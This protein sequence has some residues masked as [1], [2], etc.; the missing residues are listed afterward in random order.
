[1]SRL[2]NDEVKEIKNIYSLWDIDNRGH[3][4]TSEL[5]REI[6]LIGLDIHPYINKAIMIMD[7]NGKI[8]IKD[9]IKFLSIDPSSK[10][11]DEDYTH[12]FNLIDIN[13][14]SSIGFE[15]LAR[16]AD[17]SSDNIPKETLHSMYLST[18]DTLNDT[19]DF[20]M[21]KHILSH[22]MPNSNSPHK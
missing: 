11:T 10:G 4:D 13:G 9:L 8:D 1:M 2:T 20:S 6:S 21:F 15:E 12:I 5:Q 3:I 22:N 18:C 17:F 7:R 14:N 16:A 19:I